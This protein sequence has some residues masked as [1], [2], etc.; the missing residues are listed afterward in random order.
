[1]SNKTLKT[2][3]YGYARSYVKSGGIS[4]AQS[5]LKHSLVPLDL[6]LNDL[7]KRGV[8]FDFG[9]GEGILSNLVAHNLPE[10]QV[11]GFDLDTTRIDLAQKNRAPNSHF[12]AK[13]VF[14]L[15][16]ERLADAVIMNDFVHHFLFDQH[17]AVLA[18]AARHMKSGGVLILKEVDPMDSMDRIMTQFFDRKLYPEDALDFRLVSEWTSLLHRLGFQNVQNQ[19]IHHPWPAARTFLTAKRS[20]QD[21]NVYPDGIQAETVCTLNLSLPQDTITVFMTGATGFLGQQL[22]IHL[23]KHG[24]NNKKVRLL[25]LVRDPKRLPDKLIDRGALPL[26]GELS[27]LPRL[28]PAL[29]KV[30]YVFHLAAEVKLSGGADVWRN[31]ALG[32][33]DLVDAFQ[34]IPIQR[35]VFASTMGAVDRTQDDPC[36]MPLKESCTP[37]PL[38]LYGKAKLKAEEIIQESG[39]P[40]SMLRISW[41]F[42]PGMTPDTHVRFLSQGVVNGSPFSWFDFPGKVSIVTAEDVIQGFILLAEKKQ[43]AN[44]IFFISDGNPLSLGDLFHHVGNMV[45]RRASFIKIPALVTSVMQALRS[46]FP[47]TIQNL[48][49]DVLCVDN[50]ALTELGFKPTVSQR[51]GLRR[52]LQDL[53]LRPMDDRRL[54]TLVTGAGSGIGRALATVLHQQGHALLLVDV[55]ADALLAVA[56]PL[57]ADCL[58]LDLTKSTAIETLSAHLDSMCYRL[59]WVFNNAGIGVRGTVG[60]FELGAQE[61][62]I[63]LNCRALTAISDLALRHFREEWGHG[64]LVQIGSSAAFQPL[65]LMSAYAATKTYTRYFTH[66]LAEEVKSIPGIRVMLVNPAG[67][68]T[69]FQKTAGVNQDPGERLLTPKRVAERIVLGVHGKSTELRIGFMSH[70]MAWMGAIL[71]MGLQVRLW[72]LLMKK[73]R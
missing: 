39:L 3:I 42:G 23:L 63:D 60:Q 68:A 16:S 35:L 17:R 41:G 27:D 15:G 46:K 22:A 55:D 29:E 21:V 24:L 2:P 31:N 14:E 33:Q 56:E 61:R 7:P 9:C 20:H 18:T 44:R 30:A 13:N 52:L 6:L 32:V 73:M 59:D 65:P 40:Y 72:H 28:S 53:A 43:A 8:I 34:N 11:F 10:C 1:M 51:E 36:T 26:F 12:E 50:H 5:Y 48:H 67:V 54:V 37:N 62:V 58:V 45:G 71:P 38:S 49:S 57:G 47:I 66:A 25:I 19:R 4:W 70:A 69:H 64:T